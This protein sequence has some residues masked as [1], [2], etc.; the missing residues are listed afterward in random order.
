VGNVFVLVE[1]TSLYVHMGSL[2]RGGGG[3][4]EGISKALKKQ[5]VRSWDTNLLNGYQLLRHRQLHF[6]D[7]A[8]NLRS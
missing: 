5:F 6:R 2:S 4:R 7:V 3:V 8:I 1:D